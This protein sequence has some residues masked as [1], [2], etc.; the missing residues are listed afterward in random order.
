[1]SGAADPRRA[2]GVLVA[3][4]AAAPF[5]LAA[6]PV[7]RACLARLAADEHVLVLSVH[8]VA[9]DERSGQIFARELAALYQAVRAGEPDP[10]PALACSTRIS[11]CGSGRG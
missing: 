11:R 3:A 8:H 7:I 5:D 10:L 6:G 1:M 2:A 4:D 9:F